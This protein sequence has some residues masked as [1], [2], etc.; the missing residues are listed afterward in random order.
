MYPSS[1]S[2]TIARLMFFATSTFEYLFIKQSKGYWLVANICTKSLPGNY[3]KYLWCNVK[4]I[5]L[6]YIDDLYS[7]NPHSKMFDTN[8]CEINGP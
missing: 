5:I 2:D 8:Y 1:I 6:I 4:Q 3:V 7:L